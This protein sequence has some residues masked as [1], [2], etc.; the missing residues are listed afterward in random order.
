MTFNYFT[1]FIIIIIT[2]TEIE[3]VNKK[4]KK[5]ISPSN[6]FLITM[7]PDL[8][9]LASIVMKNSVYI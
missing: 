9:W 8:I 7:F 2:K 3:V 4:N 5:I 6:F 1:Y